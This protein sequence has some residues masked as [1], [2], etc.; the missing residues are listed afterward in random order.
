MKFD[1]VTPIENAGRNKIYIGKV[2]S[3][4]YLIK[5]YVKHPLFEKSY[6]ENRS[7]ELLCYKT[8]PWRHMPT[9][10]G[11]NVPKRYLI[12]EYVSGKQLQWSPET[13]NLV[14]TVFEKDILQ[15]DAHFLPKRRY[16]RVIPKL[17]KRAKEL[18]ENGVIKGTEMYMKLLKDNKTQLMASAKYFSHGDLRDGNLLISRA[19]V[20]IID[21]E[22]SRRDNYHY[23]LA[24]IYVD[25][26]NLS[27]Q[28][29]FY[30]VISEKS[31]FNENMFRIMVLKRCIDAM[32]SFFHRGL[33]HLDF[34]AQSVIFFNSI[35]QGKDPWN[36]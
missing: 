6:E 25:L 28:Q 15:T 32:Y 19:K 29:Y 23:D 21:F 10:V 1:S 34:Y 9:F 2:G 16:D 14:V 35:A 3:K 17:I 18:E 8:L 5:Q 30:A 4:K 22:N 24:A 36:E 26:R 31:Y 27:L 11:G 7:C 13:I 33:T 20:Y 12:T